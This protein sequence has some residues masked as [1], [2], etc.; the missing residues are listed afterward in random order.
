MLPRDPARLALTLGSFWRRVWGTVPGRVATS[1]GLDVYKVMRPQLRKHMTRDM[2]PRS[3]FLNDRVQVSFFV[4]FWN[5]TGRI[6]PPLRSQMLFMRPSPTPW[7]SGDLTKACPVPGMAFPGRDRRD[8]DGSPA[9]KSIFC[10]LH[11]PVT[12]GFLLYHHTVQEM[13]K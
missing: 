8:G 4:S 3:S 2:K 10:V 6:H 13:L 7:S 1:I 9:L 12:V 5:T 11:K